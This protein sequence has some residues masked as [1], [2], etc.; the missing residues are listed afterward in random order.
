[1]SMVPNIPSGLELLYGVLGG[2]AASDG[3]AASWVGLRAAIVYYTA[4]MRGLVSHSS[5]GCNVRCQLTEAGALQERYQFHE[6]GG[7]IM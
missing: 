1:M 2:G 4:T 7:G 6:P 3:G 5:Q